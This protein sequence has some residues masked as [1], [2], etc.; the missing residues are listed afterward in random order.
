MI[1]IGIV[2][3]YITLAILTIHFGWDTMESWTYFIGFA[4]PIIGYVYL[5]ITQR[6]LNP[7]NIFFR[8]QET[9]KEELYEQYGLIQDVSE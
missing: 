8:L 6:E 1:I 3:V 4:I 7:K 9:K 5:I 2:T